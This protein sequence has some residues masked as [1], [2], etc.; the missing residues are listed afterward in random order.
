MRIEKIICESVIGTLLNI[1]G[2]TKDTLKS[3]LDLKHMG[4]KK[5]LHPIWNRDKYIIPAAGY[6]MSSA[7]K[8]KF[9]QAL[10]NV[11]FP[12]SYALTRSVYKC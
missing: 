7:K 5:S 12:D 4:L 8:S 10:K 11:R 9:C 3:Q 6:T 2:K 1:D